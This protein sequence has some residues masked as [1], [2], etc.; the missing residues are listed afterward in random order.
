[1]VEF[2]QRQ[3]RGQLV[4]MS[5]RRWN[6]TRGEIVDEYNLTRYFV[7]LPPEAGY[8]NVRVEPRRWLGR[9]GARSGAGTGDPSFDRAFRVRPGPTPATLA[10]L[11]PALRQAMVAG[12]VPTWAIIQGTLI[13]YYDKPSKDT[14]D[15]RAEVIARIVNLMTG[16]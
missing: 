12:T 5:W 6:E 16:R 7:V 15:H 13:T 4:W 3:V 14:L 11:T 8:V 10:P 2:W 1:M 9:L